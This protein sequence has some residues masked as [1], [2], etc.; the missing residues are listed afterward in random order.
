MQCHA[1]LGRGLRHTPPC[2][3]PGGPYFSVF[4]MAMFWK[5]VAMEL[6]LVFQ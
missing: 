5:T 4:P 6:E 2:L 3:A 1:W